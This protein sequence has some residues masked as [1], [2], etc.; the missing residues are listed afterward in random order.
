MTTSSILPTTPEASTTAKGT[1][2][3]LASTIPQSTTAKS[4]VVPHL[5]KHSN[6]I[7]LIDVAINAFYRLS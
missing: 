6:L 5:G 2:T 4:T 3:P 7:T 1:T